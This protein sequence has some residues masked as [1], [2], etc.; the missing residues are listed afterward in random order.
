MSSSRQASLAGCGAVVSLPA[1]WGA[2]AGVGMEGGRAERGDLLPETRPL[3]I[4]AG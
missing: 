1:G 3:S 4:L 2:T